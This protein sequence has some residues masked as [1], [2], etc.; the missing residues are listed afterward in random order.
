MTD[1]YITPMDYTQLDSAERREIREKY[2][3][4]QKGLC[5]YCGG[6]LKD[7]PPDVITEMYID[8]N[9]FPKN[10]LRYPVH[11]Q[12]NHYTGMTEG[13]VHAYCNAVMWQYDG[14]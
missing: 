1:S 12:H 4:F 5:Y 14:R 9:L 2:I 7:S 11:L 6:K 3:E 13:A 8:W 10:F